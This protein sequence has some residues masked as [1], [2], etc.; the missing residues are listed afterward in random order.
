M[1]MRDW[2]VRIIL[3]AITLML[4]S[5][6]ACADELRGYQK[7]EG[8]Q[9]LQMGEYPYDKNG[10]VQP[11]VWR[12]LHAEDGKA[13]LLTEYVLDTSQLIF[14][15]DK[16]VI[17]QRTYRRIKTFEESDLY[18]LVDTE[19]YDRLFSNEPLAAAIISSQDHGRLFIPDRKFYLRTDYGF[20]QAAY[21]VS[22][23][24][25]KARGT[26][27]AVKVRGLYRDANGMSPY[28][29]STLKNGDQ[30]YKMQLVGYDGHLSYG[31]L[32]RVNVGLRFAAELDLSKVRT[33][34]GEGTLKDPFIL[35]YTGTAPVDFP[36]DEDDI[37]PA[38]ET[39][40]PES[41]EELTGEILPEGKETAA[42]PEPEAET[43]HTAAENDEVL[44]SFVGDCS[45]GDA[46]RSIGTANSYHSVVKREGY[47]WP[48]SAV[49]QYLSEDDMTVAN[50]E[51]VLTTSS[52]HKDIMY[53]LRA[54]PDHV[55]ILLE[56]SIE[57]VNTVNNHCYDYMRQGY[58]D[59]LE[60]LDQAGISR[61]GS[62]YYTKQDGFDDLLVK[63][64]KGIRF[65]F[66]GITYPQNSDI[67]RV[68]S[69]IAKLKDEEGC[70]IVVVSMHWGRETYLTQNPTQMSIARDL[71]DNGADIIYGHHPHVLQPMLFYH[72]KPVMFSAGNF[73]FGTMS[74][75]DKHTGIFRFYFRKNGDKAVLSKIQIIPCQ[76]SGSNDYR[77]VELTEDEQRKEVYRILCPVKES[78]GFEKPPAYFLENGTILF[79]EE[80]NMKQEL[81]D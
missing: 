37:P 20:S 46:F 78:K 41:K 56:G 11:V 18:P 45:I 80:G 59:T 42:E 5:S 9:Y 55:N 36:V 4:L 1:R 13:V 31:A 67:P 27:Y 64:V 51:V 61:F 48:F 6:P 10:T 49:Y 23:P 58:V 71:I 15:T 32:T 79:D 28:W 25:R 14:E 57:V 17:E 70:D 44:V 76:T 65:G 16:K 66:I 81:T 68:I 7:G 40:E 74:N 26:D 33:V 8:Y 63:E 19:Y 2:C 62:V 77:P 35:E 50:L 3:A 38:E 69:R 47:K 34:S 53:P 52:N 72:G 73:T 54:A 12:I 22:F 21:G 75:V 29:A 24:T 39:T 30:D 43:A 60:I